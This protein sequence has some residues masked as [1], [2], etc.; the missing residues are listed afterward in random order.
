MNNKSQFVD[1]KGQPK[2]ER[3]LY[4][5]YKPNRLSLYLLM[6]RTDRIEELYNVIYK[7]MK[8]FLIPINESTEGEK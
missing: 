2:E 1:I 5:G 8:K 4:A 3:G 7:D 6:I